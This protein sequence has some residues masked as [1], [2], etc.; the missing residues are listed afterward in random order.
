MAEIVKAKEREKIVDF[1]EE[2]VQ[3][4]KKKKNKEDKTKK[5]SKNINFLGKICCFFKDV[6]N[7][8]M[9]VHWTSKKDMLKYSIATI[10]FIVFFSLFFFGIDAIFA[11]VQSLF[12]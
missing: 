2:K 7:E 5:E 4:S 8:A 12:K 11:F 10:I 6:K 1:K 3:K 9:K